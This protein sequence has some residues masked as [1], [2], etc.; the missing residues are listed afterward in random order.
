MTEKRKHDALP[1]FIVREEDKTEFRAD[2][3]SALLS[4]NAALKRL[5]DMPDLEIQNDAIAIDADCVNRFVDERIKEIMSTKMMTSDN[6]KAAKKEWEKIRHAAL[7]NIQVI[8][9]FFTGY[10]DAETRQDGDTIVCDNVDALVNEHCKRVVPKDA[11]VH[12]ELW[13]AV[14]DAIDELRAWER[15]RDLKKFTLEGVLR[16]SF[17]PEQFAKWWC[18]GSF[19]KNRYEKAPQAE[20]QR[21]A[22]EQ[23]Y[24]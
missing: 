11:Q 9:N 6:K 5:L 19:N 13:C 7:E 17:S 16:H 20:M 21:K 18:E 12:Y 3:H 4:C 22:N 8:R 15:E 1:S 24:L 10:P 2:F 14:R 23:Y